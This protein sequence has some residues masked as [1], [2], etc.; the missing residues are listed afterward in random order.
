MMRKLVEGEFEK[1]RSLPIVY[2]PA[3]STVIP[4]SPKLT[5]VIEDGMGAMARENSSELSPILR[6]PLFVHGGYLLFWVPTP[7]PF[8]PVCQVRG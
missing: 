7:E 3:E 8:H 6:M 5:S 4:D 1:G 2:A